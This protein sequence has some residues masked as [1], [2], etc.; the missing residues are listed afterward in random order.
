MPRTPHREI[1]VSSL[2]T[3]PTMIIAQAF[4]EA[5]EQGHFLVFD[6][7]DSLLSDR[8]HAVRNWEVNQVNEMFTWMEHHPLPF[9]CTTNYM[10]RLDSATLRRFDFKI[11]LDYLSAE[12]AASAFRSFFQ[13][14]PPREIGS[15]DELTPGDFAVV[16]RRAE[17]LGVLED[18]DALVTMLNEECEAKPGSARRIG[19]AA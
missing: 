18:R 10:D 17:L 5:R 19:F 7:A 14:E 4:A 13:L 15:L 9:A 16:K 12:Q 1:I 6:E 8:R 3:A 11:A 2:T